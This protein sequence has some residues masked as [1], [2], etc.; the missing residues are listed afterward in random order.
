VE[1]LDEKN[2]HSALAPRPPE[3]VEGAEDLPLPG[4]GVDRR[5]RMGR[6]ADPEKLVEKRKRH[7]E[8]GVEVEHGGGELPAGL[9]RVVGVGD[10]ELGSEELE[11]REERYRPGVGEAVGGEDVGAVGATR[12]RELVGKAA[13]A[14]TGP[15]HDAD[16]LTVPF[17][18]PEKSGVERRHVRLPSDETGEAPRRRHLEGSAGG[19]SPQKFEDDHLV[20]GAFDFGEAEVGQFEVALDQRGCCP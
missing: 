2:C 12:L 8:F 15:G 13:L 16:D 3:P 7:V 10:G 9:V 5:C 6:V 19:A 18:G 17:A 20:A 1:I 11:D 14:D 4:L